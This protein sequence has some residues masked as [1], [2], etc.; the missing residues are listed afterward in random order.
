MARLIAASSYYACY[1]RVYEDDF[2]IS[3]HLTPEE[4]GFGA[5]NLLHIHTKNGVMEATIPQPK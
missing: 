4:G 2:V 5:G 1:L 3:H